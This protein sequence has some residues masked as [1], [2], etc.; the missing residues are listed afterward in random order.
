MKKFSLL[1]SLVFAA[2]PLLAQETEFECPPYTYNNYY[3]LSLG[4]G[5][6]Q[7]AGALSWMH[8]YG[9]GAKE[10]IKIGY[11]LRFN[12]YLG[13]D[14]D[15]RTAPASLT[16]GRRGLGA[17]FTERLEENIDTLYMA[18]AQ[19]NSINVMIGLQYTINPWLEAGVNLD[20]IGISFGSRRTGEFSGDPD[21]DGPQEAR[22]VRINL[23][24]PGD[25]GRGTLASE[26]YLRY[27][28]TE[29]FALKGGLGF[30]FSEYRT[31][32]P[33]T[34]DNERFRNRSL[35]GVIGVTFSPLRMP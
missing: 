15:Y 30:F 13:K 33:L 5:P 25:I 24:M 12:S 6:N 16:R 21:F 18:R 27:W 8:F 29:K 28:M 1:I 35:M 26:I 31:S 4:A 2:T 11:G 7:L 19:V 9:L 17:L 14:Q 10:K 32:Q 22:P 34:F 20:L 3:S 23:M